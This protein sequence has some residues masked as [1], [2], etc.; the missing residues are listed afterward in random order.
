MVSD[1]SLRVPTASLKKL[2][3]ENP[4]T[5]LQLESM[6]CEK[7]AEELF[8]KVKGRLSDGS[9]N[10]TAKKLV[11][12]EVNRAFHALKSKFSF[13]EEGKKVIQELATAAVQKAMEA[14][15]KHL[16]NGV[17]EKLKAMVLRIGGEAQ[18]ALYEQLNKD[19]QERLSEMSSTIRQMARSEFLAV[20][21]E[22]KAGLE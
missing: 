7:I 13:P 18:T 15:R 8:Q 5:K 6:A 11:Q 21:A 2:L 14:E 4:E 1:L 3:D 9:V 16:L 17:E 10:E 19:H 12:D 20:L 22:A